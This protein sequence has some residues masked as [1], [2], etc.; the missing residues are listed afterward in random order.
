MRYSPP[1]T[2]AASLSEPSS[3][4]KRSTERMVTV[5][6]SRE[7]VLKLAQSYAQHSPV[8]ADIGT[9][10]G[11]RFIT[12]DMLRAIKWIR[13]DCTMDRLDGTHQAFSS[14]ALLIMLDQG[15]I[16]AVLRL[17]QGVINAYLIQKIKSVC[18][19]SFS[20]IIHLSK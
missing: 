6:R 17:Y 18:E 10:R 2:T 12:A 7:L 3:C 9:K 16:K 5:W 13:L 11:C 20:I 1:C 19:Q 15:S 14:N 8:P 4:Y